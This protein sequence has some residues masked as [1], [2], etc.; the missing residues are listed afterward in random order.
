MEKRYYIEIGNRF[1]AF[2]GMQVDPVMK[3]DYTEA[4]P[5][6]SAEK[7][8]IKANICGLQKY[9]ILKRLY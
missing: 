7:A 8:K 4:T 9:N 6:L 2:T 5:F 3:S 1:A